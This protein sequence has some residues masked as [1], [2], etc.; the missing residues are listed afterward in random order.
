MKYLFVALLLIS[1]FYALSQANYHK[2]SVTV[3]N[4]KV[5]NGYINYGE[6]NLNPKYIEFKSDLNSKDV[7]KYYPATTEAFEINGIEKYVRYSGSISLNHVNFPGLTYGQ[8]TTIKQD[9]VFLRQ[10]AS[11][12]N[13]TLYSYADSLKIRYFVQDKHEQPIELS[14]QKYFDATGANTLTSKR[15]LTQLNFLAGKYAADNTRL[16]NKIA[17]ADYNTNDIENIV[18]ELNSH[19][20]IAKPTE[21]HS[22]YIS[23][24]AGAGVS[25]SKTRFLGTTDLANSSSTSSLPR[26]DV[27]IDIFTNRT[28][29]KFKL[30][31][32]IAYTYINPTLTGKQYSTASGPFVE[33]YSF[34]QH[35]FTISPQVIWNAYNTDAFKFFVGAGIGFNFSSYPKN[36]YGLVGSYNQSI[37]PFKLQGDWFNLPVQAGIVLNK[38]FEIFASY[39]ADASFLID[40]NISL[41]SMIFNGGI[42]YLFK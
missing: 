26:L 22:F 1:P 27:G 30:R 29:Q 32:D 28:I 37:I 9:I 2:G 7:I 8:D 18:N 24:F 23:Y 41:S 40:S 31:I 14:Y 19:Q 3:T 38:R 17:Q 33:T 21:H 42:H 15:Y 34:T 12:N 20:G 11:G 25:I 39:T 6:W 35:T 16:T 13:V 4:D 5:L 10:I 36:T